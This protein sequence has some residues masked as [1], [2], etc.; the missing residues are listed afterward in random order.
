M[1]DHVQEPAEADLVATRS[2][3]VRNQTLLCW[4]A[5]HRSA[6]LC[7]PLAR[8]DDIGGP[9]VP[10]LAGRLHVVEGRLYGA[11]TEALPDTNRLS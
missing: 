3:N 2:R 10:R 6:H 8:F 7:A 9:S 1:V 11:Q 4:L 5:R